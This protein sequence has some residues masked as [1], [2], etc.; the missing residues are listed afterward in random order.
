[1]K[2][3]IEKIIVLYIQRKK[4]ELKLP[5]SQRTL[6]IIDGF[7]ALCTTDVIKL[8]DHHAIDI[9]YVPAKCTGELQSL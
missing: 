8:L 3:Y 6:C 9:V 1:M 2:L 7:R 5:S 4:T